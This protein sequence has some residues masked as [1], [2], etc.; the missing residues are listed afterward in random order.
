MRNGMSIIETIKERISCRTY[1]DRPIEPDKA[2]TLKTFLKENTIS[3]FGSEIRFQLLDF[4]EPGMGETRMRGTYGVIKGAR[5]FMAGAVRNRP[6]AMED[7]GYCMEKN[8]LKATSLG[9]GTCWLGGTFNRTGFAE[10]IKIVD[11]ELLPAVSPVGYSSDRRSL[12]DRFF[13]FS[14]GSDK[15]KSWHE[16]FFDGNIDNPLQKES[17]GP[18]ETALACLRIGPSASNMQ[19][20]RIIKDN[21]ILHF[22]LKRTRGYNSVLGDIKLQNMDMGI[23]MCHFELSSAALGLR[24]NWQVNDPRIQA[25]EMEYIASWISEA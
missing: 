7:Y 2:E 13:R 14:A 24:G 3:P 6:K 11:G 12:V 25:G 19:P 21:N 4:T 8:I 20:W 22:Y 1:S 9:L 17:A 23:A 18:Y 15:R 10:K 5:Q 16:L